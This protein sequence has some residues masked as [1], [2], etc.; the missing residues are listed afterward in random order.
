MLPKVFNQREYQTVILG[1]LLHDIGKMLQRGSFGSLDTSGKH[2]IVSSVFVSA[3]RDFFSRFADFDLLLTLVQRHHEDK[4]LG[5]DLICQ[6]APENSK[7]LSYLVSRADNYSSSERGKQAETYQD[8]KLTPM[9]SVFSR[10]DLAKG[11]PGMMRYKLNHLMPENTFPEKFD[12]YDEGEFNA[13]LQGFGE[14]F[15]TLVSGMKSADF[16]ALFSNVLTILL[17]YSWCI[18][19]NTQEEYPDVSLFDHLR[20][21]AAIAAC[22]YQYHS[23]NFLENKIKED[24]TEKFVLLVGDLSGIQNYLF[25]ITHI[26]AGGTAKRLRARSFQ[27]NMLSEIV[28][29]KILHAF[30]LPLAN[31][32]MTSGGKFYV[33]LP[34]KVDTGDKIEDIKTEIDA[35]FHEKL[36]AEIN[37]NIATRPLSG[38]N[39]SHYNLIMKSLNQRLQRIKKQPFKSILIKNDAWQE[40][41]TTL[42]VDYGAEERLCKACAKLPGKEREDGKHICDR[43]QAD[44]DIG[45]IL[46]KA[47]I[48]AFYKDNGGRFKDYFGYSIDL[49]DDAKDVRNGC[50]LMMSMDEPFSHERFPVAHRFI[51]NYT[52]RFVSHDECAPCKN[53]DCTERGNVWAGQPKSFECIAHESTGRPMLGYLKAD[54]DNLG[55]VFAFGL[56]DN[57]TVS[58]IA[59]LSRMLDVFFSGYMQKLIENNYPELYTVY[60]GGDDL[61]VIGPWDSTIRFADEL[62]SEFGRFTCN[63][64]NLTISAGIGFVKHHHPVFRAVEMADNALDISKDGGKNRLTVFGQTVEWDKVSKIIAESERLAGWLKNRNISTGF[65]RNLLFYSQM[66][67]EFM[68]TGKTE[69]LRFLPLMTYDI[70]RN[71]PPVESQDLQKREIRAWAESLKSDSLHMQ[72][73]GIIANYALSANRGGKDE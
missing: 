58:R 50:Y 56:K 53:G 57:G 30:N 32:L 16:D 47:T 49:L 13:H 4:R 63:N 2:P 5:D 25:N 18:P 39:F 33:L 28:S 31:I 26:G 60:S 40:H 45:Q 67:T 1:A 64:K 59:T 34:N 68:K 55:A 41:N 38:K 70:A 35:W 24:K 52:A 46:P 15:N 69:H 62:N 43:C 8:Y 42:N 48:L 71:L 11:M 29:H 72:H 10:I 21:T 19:S 54:V 7:S 12:T 17:R 44:K 66:N 36:Q 51:A 6:N 61:L 20:T 3:F 23:P 27:L 9:V 73:L 14:E 65:A 37:V 22:L